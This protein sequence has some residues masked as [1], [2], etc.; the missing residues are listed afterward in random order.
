MKKIAGILL[1]I[2]S[3]LALI[4][5]LVNLP[6]QFNYLRG[7][8]LIA[9]LFIWP[10]HSVSMILLGIYLVS[11]NNST[12]PVQS[13]SSFNQDFNPENSNAYDVPSTGLNIISFLIP[14]VGLIVYLT[15]KDKSPIKAGSAGKSALWGVGVSFVLVIISVI[16][17]ISII[18]SIH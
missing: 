2:S 12:I 13:G 9:S 14:L 17:S 8:Q 11:D 4:S 3:S 7:F 18:N 16:V 10:L 6:E 15:E 5:Q 1:I